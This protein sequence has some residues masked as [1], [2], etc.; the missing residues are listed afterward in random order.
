MDVFQTTVV[1]CTI[2][3]KFLHACSQHSSESKSLSLRFQWD[4]RVLQA[5]I[6]I[7]NDSTGQQSESTLTA[8]E[9]AMIGDV[10]DYLGQFSARLARIRQRLESTNWWRTKLSLATWALHRSELE[11][12]ESELFQWTQ[13]FDLRLLGLP[14]RAQTAILS[15][16]DHHQESSKPTENRP[17]N[18]TPAL[19]IQQRVATFLSIDARLQD[20]IIQ[21]LELGIDENEAPKPLDPTTPQHSAR[22]LAKWKDQMVLIEYKVADSNKHWKEQ[23]PQ[24]GMLSAVLNQADP[25][26]IG[27]L[28]CVGYFNESSSTQSHE[29][30]F[31]FVY[32]LPFALNVSPPSLKELLERETD[33]R[34]LRADHPLNHRLTLIRHLAR[35]LYFLHSMGWVHKNIR[36]Q[37]VLVLESSTSDPHTRFP[38]GLGL[39]VLIDF[40]LA[41]ESHATSDLT[42]SEYYAR[43]DIELYQHPDRQGQRAKERFV[44]AH[45][46]Y[47]FGVVMLEL[48]LWRPLNLLPARFERK[49]GEQIRQGLLALTRE[50]AVFMGERYASIIRW[51]LKRTSAE[52]C[53]PSQFANKVLQQ[54]EDIY[55][56]MS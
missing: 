45:D 29:I 42:Q 15:L 44:A 28:R 18:F 14:S 32:S 17:V 10:A 19:R 20:E 12:L 21:G 3:Y 16:G 22:M 24:I 34:R 47:S 51:C 33:G 54:V 9:L 6:D 56:A 31:G 37:N 48:G 35:S 11:K 40:S 30:R 38:R 27:L 1:S 8:A 55:D 23:K 4:I 52:E 41:R 13:R 7:T 46:V 26:T 36:P 2:I 53:P 50:C 5:I 39:P 43:W 25:Y 49:S